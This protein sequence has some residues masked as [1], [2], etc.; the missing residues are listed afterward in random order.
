M[1]DLLKDI[2]SKLGFKSFYIT[3]GTEKAPC[4]VYN[5]ILKPCN[6][7]DNKLESMEYTVLL[8]LYVTSNIEKSKEEILKTILKE[9][10]TI[11]QV[12][13]TVLEENGTFNTAMKFKKILKIKE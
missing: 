2:F 1:N 3:R 10:F 9:E 11:I 13:E 6:Y 8:N 5:Y 4:I 7:S 12:Q